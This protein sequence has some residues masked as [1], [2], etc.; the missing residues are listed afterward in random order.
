MEPMIEDGE[1]ILINPNQEVAHGDVAIVCWNGRS[2][3]RGVKFERDGAV[4]L[5]PVNK[6]YDEDVISK[7]DRSFVLEFCG[8]VVRFLGKDRVSR[9]IL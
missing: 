7:E 8:V 1:R 9:G 6:D 5:V 3:V 2:M 4:R